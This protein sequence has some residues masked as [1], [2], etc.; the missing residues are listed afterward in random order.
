MDR[1][2]EEQLNNI[3]KILIIQL[4]PFGDAL[5]TTSYF[6]TLKRRLPGTSL[7]YLVK[8]PYDRIIRDHPAIDETIVIPRRRGIGYAIERLKTVG[9]I[10][11]RGF[12]L[13]IDQ[14]NMPSSQQLTVLSGARYRLGYRDARLSW[15]YN[16]KAGRG[17]LRYS[18]SRKFDILGPLGIEEQPY[19]LCFKI[20][21]QVQDYMDSWLENTPFGHGEAICVSPGSPVRSKRW[22]PKG[23]ARL[24][25]LIQSQTDCRVIL[26]WGPDEREDV[27][28]VASRMETGP[29]VA[30]P[31][32][33]YQA[34]AL[35]KRCRLLICNDGG[36][37]HMAVT[38]GTPTVAIFGPTDPVAWSPASVFPS[39]HHLH[40]PECD[41]AKDDSFGITPEMAFDKVTEIL[42][43]Q[44]DGKP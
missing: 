35:L 32:D 2:T 31:T 19:R 37:N 17:P 30:P 38:T 16:L 9:R 18:A 23:F 13:V 29:L 39:H 1:L 34:A 28:A 36:L 7:S 15:A 6:E 3:R 40:C 44:T 25:D 42:K 21:G 14:Q 24:V 10:R 22:S 4:G 12:D 8:E 43:R 20:P 5:L 41:W 33:L 27:N 26:L 11:N